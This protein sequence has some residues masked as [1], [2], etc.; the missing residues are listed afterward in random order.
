MVATTPTTNIEQAKTIALF[1]FS[2]EKQAEGN[3]IS[4]G[5]ANGQIALGF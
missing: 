4:L 5:V 3:D 1:S 2:Y